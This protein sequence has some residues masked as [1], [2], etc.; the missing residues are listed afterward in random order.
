MSNS[1]SRSTSATR[2]TSAYSYQPMGYSGTISW[3][4]P[5]LHEARA[6][7]LPLQD[8]PPCVT[9]LPP[10]QVTDEA[11]YRRRCLKTLTQHPPRHHPPELSLQRPWLHR[12]RDLDL[13]PHRKHR[14]SAAS[15]SSS[16][17]STVCAGSGAC[18]ATRTL[19]SCTI[20]S[21]RSASSTCLRGHVRHDGHSEGACRGHR[22][23]DHGRRD[24]AQVPS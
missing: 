21:S 8:D 18:S 14:G 19:T 9:T 2:P 1:C 6:P 4:F 10:L 23:G 24:D 20:P 3:P 5:V 15:S 16:A 12:R 7:H 22:Q 11:R 13:S 17:V